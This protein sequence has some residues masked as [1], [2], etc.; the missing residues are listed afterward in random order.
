MKDSGLGDGV[1][2]DQRNTAM[3]VMSD[4]LEM[5]TVIARS[6]DAL[7]LEAV[8]K[9]ANRMAANRPGQAGNQQ[10]QAQNQANQAQN[11]ANQAG[12]GQG[13]RRRGSVG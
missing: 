4:L 9:P 10:N 7:N 13:R 12:N 5:P 6:R 3:T 2:L 11:Q 1:N 8:K